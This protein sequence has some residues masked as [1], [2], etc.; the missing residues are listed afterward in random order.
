MEKIWLKSYDEGVPFTREYPTLPLKHYFNKWVE[1]NPDKPYLIYNDMAYSYKESNNIICRLANALIDMGVKKGD[2]LALMA[3]NI[4]Q[5]VLTVQ[6]CFKSG[7]ILVAC[8]PL[9]TV[10]ELTANFK[11]NGTETVVVMAQFADKAVEILKAGQTNLKRVIVVQTPGAE[12]AIEK[13]DGVLDFDEVVASGSE[14]EVDVE[15]YSQDI[16]MLQYTGGTTGVSKGCGLT[17]FNLVATAHNTASWMGVAV[18]V[19]EMRTLA[20]LP[21]Y[22]IFGYNQNINLTLMGGGTIVCCTDPSPAG[23]LKTIDQHEPNWAAFVP[24]IV[25]GLANNPKT[26]ESKIRSLKGLICGGAAIPVEAKKEFEKI[27]GA[28]ITEGYG[29]SETCQVLTCTPFGIN[30]P[31]SIGCPWPDVDMKIVDLE[32]GTKEMPL[33]E[34]GEIIAKAPQVMQGGYWGRPKETAESIKDGYLYTGDIAYMDEDGFVYIIDRKK[35]MI[36]CSGFNVYPRDIDEVLFAHPKV[37]EALTVGIPDPK[38]GETIKVAV[39]VKP[40]ETLTEEEVIAYCREQL[41]PYKV[42]KIVEFVDEVPKTSVGKPDRKAL[43]AAELAKMK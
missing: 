1:A 40:G 33:G 26:P 21:L 25:V 24:A 16:A 32:T 4:P 35:D 7:V 41:A 22:H 29:L 31:G 23:V 8:N 13:V 42:P 34:P 43:K 14:R 9:Y 2:R 39:A 12:I 20:V 6:T 36:I 18:P 19:E 30:K 37:L 15:V 17:N 38:R 27:S 5:Y 11:D 10:P 3:T 28:I